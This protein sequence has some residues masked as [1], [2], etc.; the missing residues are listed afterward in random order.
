MSWSEGENSCTVTTFDIILLCWIE[1]ICSMIR[2]DR[3]IW[4]KKEPPWSLIIWSCLR[5]PY[6]VIIFTGPL[7]CGRTPGTLPEVVMHLPYLASC[8][9]HHMV[10]DDLTSRTNGSL[11][12]IAQGQYRSSNPPAPFGGLTLSIALSKDFCSTF[13][14]N[15]RILNG[16][17]NW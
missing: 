8:T 7:E 10:N 1:V 2:P 3:S 11:I 14:S 9:F 16:E 5:I 17:L 6:C 12:R 15:P 13:H 4:W